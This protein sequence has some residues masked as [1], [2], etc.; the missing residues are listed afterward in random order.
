MQEP[1]EA[2][3]ENGVFRPLGPVDL[4]EH[5]H[6]RIEP[7]DT[8]AEASITSPSPQRATGAL[9]DLPHWDEDLAAIYA[10]RLQS[11]CREAPQ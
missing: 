5:A 11:P 2:V 3:Y 7:A 6:V 8:G 4:P 9:A 1:I 10:E